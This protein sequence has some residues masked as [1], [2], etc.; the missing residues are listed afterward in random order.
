MTPFFDGI[1]KRS[2]LFALQSFS[3]DAK[4]FAK[5]QALAPAFGGI[6]NNLRFLTLN[7]LHLIFRKVLDGARKNLFSTLHFQKN[8]K[9]VGIG[10]W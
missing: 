7:P 9:T 4:G 8:R 10:R 5:S 6:S 1:V 2:I 3:G